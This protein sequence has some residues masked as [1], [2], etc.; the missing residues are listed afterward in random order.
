MP[1]CWAVASAATPSAHRRDRRKR[2]SRRASSGARRLP[3][4]ASA[5]AAHHPSSWY[6]SASKPVSPPMSGRQRRRQH[7]R[8]QPGLAQIAG[9]LRQ[10]VQQESGRDAAQHHLLHAAE[11]EQPQADRR[12]PAAP[13]R[14]VERLRQQLID[15]AADSRRRRGRHSRRARYKTTA[16]RTA[17]FRAW[18]SFR[19]TCARRQVGLE[20][21]DL[22]VRG[23]RAARRR[24]GRPP[25]ASSRSPDV[26]VLASMRSRKRPD[27]S[28]RKTRHAAKLDA[29][30]AARLG[31][32]DRLAVVAALAHPESAADV[33][34]SCVSRPNSS[35]S[36]RADRSRIVA[37][38]GL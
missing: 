28:N 15:T 16:A 32:D 23:R 17:R 19:A 18:R 2:R 1:R 6:S 5:G 25:A 7:R 27:W 34:G 11:A 37:E 26:R 14:P 21:V 20:I 10:H 36:S 35:A 8:H 29:L 3:R 12:R 13:W 30:L 24:R 38:S 33:V 4:G 9:H 31:V 22:V